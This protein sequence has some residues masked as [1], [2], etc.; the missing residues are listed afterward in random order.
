MHGIAN[1]SGITGTSPVMTMGEAYVLI[2]LHWDM[3]QADFVLI[4]PRRTRIDAQDLGLRH[5][6]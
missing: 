3:L 1:L 5:H 4:E 2:P 6:L